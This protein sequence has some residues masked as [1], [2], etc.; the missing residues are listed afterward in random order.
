M[1]SDVQLHL[2]LSRASAL[3]LSRSSSIF[4]FYLRFNKHIFVYSFSFILQELICL[5]REQFQIFTNILSLSLLLSFPFSSRS[6]AGFSV[7]CLAGS[8][9]Q[10]PLPQTTPAS[11]VMASRSFDI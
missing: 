10:F 9:D 11:K 6:R 4:S 7:A 1:E 2:S 8:S 5:K 3:F